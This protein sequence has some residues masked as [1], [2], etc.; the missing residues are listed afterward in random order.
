M[1]YHQI[2]LVKKERENSD[3]PRFLQNSKKGWVTAEYNMLPRAT[4]YRKD[5]D[6]NKG[7]PN[8]RRVEIQIQSNSSM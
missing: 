5:R 3:I 1:R 8:G 6:V 2:F 7:K 4:H